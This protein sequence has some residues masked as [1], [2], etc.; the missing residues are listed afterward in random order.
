V[1]IRFVLELPRDSMSVPVVRR[2]L[3]RSLTTLG[4]EDSCVADIEIALT[5]A[6]TNVLDH[7]VDGDEYEVSAGVTDDVC[8]ID[9]IDAGRGFDAEKLGHSQADHS[10]EEGRGLQLIRALV[11]HVQF[12]NRPEKG[13]IVHFQKQ[14]DFRDGAPFRILLRRT[15]DSYPPEPSVVAEREDAVRLVEAMGPD[16]EPTAG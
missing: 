12:T 7:A 5:E 3:N 11:D 6:C 13:T 2:I 9:V 14:L 16:P 1:E 15:N 8:V 4:V 10:A